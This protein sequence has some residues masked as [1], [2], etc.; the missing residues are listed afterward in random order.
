MSQELISW[1]KANANCTYCI[2]KSKFIGIGI[3]A[4][5]L[6]LLKEFKT[7]K[8]YNNLFEFK[9]LETGTYFIAVHK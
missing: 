7:L 5:K 8:A 4:D 1:C 2:E 3:F 6:R 9:K